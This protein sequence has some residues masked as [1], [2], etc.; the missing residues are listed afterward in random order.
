M[1]MTVKQVIEWLSKLPDKSI[2]IMV[3]CPNCGHGQQ[4][5][6]MCEAVIM[7][8]KREDRDA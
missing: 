4:L 2:F 5:A 8:G 7:Q 1:P 3:D 6:A